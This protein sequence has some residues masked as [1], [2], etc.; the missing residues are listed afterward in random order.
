LNIEYLRYAANFINKKTE[1]SDFHQSPINNQQSPIA[2]RQSTIT[3]QQSNKVY[4]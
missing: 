1:R 2:N 3:N 4:R